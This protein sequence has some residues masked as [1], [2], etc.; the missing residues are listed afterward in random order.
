MRNRT[1][2]GLSHRI[3]L[4]EA[5]ALY[6]FRVY[7][8]VRFVRFDGCVILWWLQLPIHVRPRSFAKLDYHHRRICVFPENC[9]FYIF[10][11]VDPLDIT[12]FSLRSVNE[13]GM[14][15]FDTT[16]PGQHR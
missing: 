13:P 14:E 4:N 6:V 1:C 11:Y 5:W 16:R 9:R 15:N 8:Y 10:L 7:Q 2:R 3:L 12:P